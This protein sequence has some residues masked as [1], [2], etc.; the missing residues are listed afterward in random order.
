M[1]V[2]TD[3]GGDDRSWYDDASDSETAEDKETPSTVECIS[4]QASKRSN[5]YRH[6]S[7]CFGSIGRLIINLDTY[8][9]S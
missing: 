2:W 4:P 7:Q 8:P 5:A 3:D 6:S 1:Y 9:L